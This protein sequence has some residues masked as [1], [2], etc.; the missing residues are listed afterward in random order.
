MNQPGTMTLKV[1]LQPGR[2]SDIMTNNDVDLS[3]SRD[4]VFMSTMLSY[5]QH[6]L[7]ER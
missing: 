5:W 6:H 3:A 7:A 1:V 4:L 2:V